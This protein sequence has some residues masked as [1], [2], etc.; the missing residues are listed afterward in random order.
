MVNLSYHGLWVGYSKL[1]NGLIAAASG[2]FS[3]QITLSFLVKPKEILFK[4]KQR[5][6][7]FYDAKLKTIS[8]NVPKKIIFQTPTVQ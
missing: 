6:H 7:R 4:I 1:T 3:I 8:S 5:L 2:A